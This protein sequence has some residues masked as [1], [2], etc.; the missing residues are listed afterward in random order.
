MNTQKNLS[1]LYLQ[2]FR[3]IEKMETRYFSAHKYKQ[4]FY[5]EKENNQ[6]V[7]NVF[8]I[9]SKDILRMQEQHHEAKLKM[10]LLQHGIVAEFDKITH[11][12]LRNIVLE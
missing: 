2:G 3:E 1:T 10:L 12:G 7:L 6:L 9:N 4:V 11:H 5:M 8:S